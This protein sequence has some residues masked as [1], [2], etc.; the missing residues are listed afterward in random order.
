MAVRYDGALADLYWLASQ[1]AGWVL[2][3]ENS[4][5]IYVMDSGVWQE[6]VEIYRPTSINPATKDVTWARYLRTD[7]LAPQQAPIGLTLTQQNGTL[8]RRHVTATWTNPTF[9]ETVDGHLRLTNL[10]DPTKNTTA[11]IVP[12]NGTTSHQFLDAGI[13]GDTVQVDVWYSENGPANPF[14]SPTA[15]DTLTFT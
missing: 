7:A 5:R 8:G 1:A 14:E 9:L 3:N 10:D 2:G 12:L 6:A 13:S 4:Y 15:T 11:D